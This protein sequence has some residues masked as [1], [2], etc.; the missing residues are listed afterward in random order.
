MV[1]QILL[2]Y[3]QE[4]NKRIDERGVQMTV[5][6]QILLVTLLIAAYL[7]YLINYRRNY[8][9]ERNKLLFL[10]FQLTILPVV[11]GW[12]L[13]RGGSLMV[14]PFAIAPVM[15]N[16][17]LDSRTAYITHTIIILITSLIV[18]DPIIF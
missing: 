6:G 3:Q 10:I 8:L 14:I 13:N 7:I 2:S 12:L 1:Y 5:I 4:L 17:F 9:Y 11:A 15:I 18:P 16:V